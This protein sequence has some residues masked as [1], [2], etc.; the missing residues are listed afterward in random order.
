MLI[1]PTPTPNETYEQYTIRAHRELIRQVPDPDERNIMVWSAWEHNRGLTPA[2][3]RAA[4]E[5]GD[6]ERFIAKPNVCYFVEH[7]T[8]DSRGEQVRFGLEDLVEIQRNCNKRASD[9][10]AFAAIADNHTSP[11]D[12]SH[13]GDP[14]VLGVVG[15]YKLGM[16]GHEEPKWAIFAD[17]Y[18]RADKAEILRDKPRRSIELVTF[19]NTGERFIDP[20]AALGGRAPRLPMPSQYSVASYSADGAL[21]SRYMAGQEMFPGPSNTHIKSTD[22][23]SEPETNESNMSDEDIQKIISA[24]GNM[25]EFVWVRD[26]MDSENGGAVNPDAMGGMDDVGGP[27]FGEEDIDFGDDD[28]FADENIE[29]NSMYQAGGASGAGV[30]TPPNN[31]MY[32]NPDKFSASYNA[33]NGTNMKNFVTIEQYN[34]LA[35]SHKNVLKEMGVLA[36]HVKESNRKEIDAHRQM[37]INQLCGEYPGIYDPQEE[38]SRLLYSAGANLSNK[39]FDEEIQRMEALA[40][41][42]SIQQNSI[43]R[44]ETSTYRGDQGASIERNSAWYDK[45]QQIQV[46][47][48]N[49]DEFLTWDEL[50]R[51]TDEA[52]KK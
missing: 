28:M 13:A 20:V 25:P 16:I 29:R 23:F 38:C 52:L 47:A 12:Q 14:P 33:S 17:E 30:V 19:H 37:R 24:I 1:A 45:C 4:D 18:H 49:R 32:E 50:S 39:K 41:R 15:N 42:V 6:S 21:I 36:S 22:Y 26:Q 27:G 11:T 35:T 7:E 46:E 48:A 40:A 3:Q 44:G 43:P 31:S 51:L 8:I 5:F 34:A 2:Q 9:R 10:K